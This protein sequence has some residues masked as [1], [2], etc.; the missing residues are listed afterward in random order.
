MKS[1]KAL[2]LA[3]ACLGIGAT[4]AASWPQKQV[5]VIV[6]YAAG[7]VTDTMARLVFDQV[8]RNTGQP[9]VV[10]NRGG[11]SGMIG[12]SIVTKAAPDGYTLVVAP[13][14]PLATNALLYKKLPYDLKDLTPVAL[15]GETPS[16]LLVSNQIPANSAPELLKFMG[17]PQNRLA[18]AS[19]GVGTLSHLYMAYL[20]S[21]SGG[22]LPH[23]VYQSG[24]QIMTGLIAN[25]IQVATMPPIG[26]GAFVS[27]GKMKA[28][29]MVGPRRSP[30]MP[31]LATL[32]EQGIDFAPVGWFGVAT[33]GGTPADVVAA[34]NKAI[35][36]ALKDPAV[37]EALNQRG[38]DV[39]EKTAPEFAS[40]VSEDLARWRP[41][42][43]KH[44]IT[45][46]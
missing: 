25:D 22:E 45:V 17:N 31:N 24:G 39:I 27:Q 26:I 19:P 12:T 9:F 3:A 13:S 38:M 21:L 23:I 18:Y 42:V 10:E 15:L 43:A 5:R 29:A 20:V 36:T 16:V 8:Q 33:T 44:K 1:F 2:I 7:S 34:I 32:R 6:P 14:A 35:T 46:E 28:I 40:Y 11:A 30:L 37:L 41:F 4:Q